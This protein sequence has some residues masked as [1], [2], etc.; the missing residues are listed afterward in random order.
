MLIEL[1]VLSHL[2]GGVHSSGPHGASHGPVRSNMQ[3]AVAFCTKLL[4]YA[5]FGNMFYNT[6]D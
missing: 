5:K 1:I 6:A 2:T 4:A 3:M